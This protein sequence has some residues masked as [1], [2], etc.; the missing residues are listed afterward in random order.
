MRS[1]NVETVTVTEMATWRQYFGGCPKAVFVNIFLPLW[2]GD[3][4]VICRSSH[5]EWV[6]HVSD[7]IHLWGRSQDQL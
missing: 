6:P 1:V 7:H 3:V 2:A 4:E 5:A